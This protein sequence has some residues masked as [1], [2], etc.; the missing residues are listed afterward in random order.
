MR[1]PPFLRLP[2]LPAGDDRPDAF[3]P[4]LD[5]R[6]IISPEESR[7][8]DSCF[9]FV[10]AVSGVLVFALFVAPLIAALVVRLWGQ[11]P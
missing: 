6:A 8:I 9:D 11:L 4:R 1:R 10:A 7:R 2:E 5:W 3:E